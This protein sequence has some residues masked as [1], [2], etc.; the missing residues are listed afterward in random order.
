LFDTVLESSERVFLCEM[1]K[2]RANADAYKKLAKLAYKKHAGEIEKQL[3]G[4]G[5]QLDTSLSDREHKVFYNP[6][7]KK[8]VVAYRGTDPRDTSSI[9]TDVRSDYHILLGNEGKD[10]RFKRATKQ[11][12]GVLDKYQHQ[13][14][15]F[16][17]T[18]HS[19]GG[20][21][22][23]HV[24]KKFPKKVHENLS[25]SRGSGLL[26]PFRTRP[27]NTW[28]Y[29]H[30]KDPISLGARLSKDVDGSTEHSVVSHTRVRNMINAHDMERLQTHTEIPPVENTTKHTVPDLNGNKYMQYM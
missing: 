6:N 25:Y 14:Y 9:L 5:F 1:K 21:L 19:L 2:P 15:S 20:A 8:V 30:V 26:E 16:D 10:S 27:Q 23:T 18:G 13:G 11:F 7:T 22:A 17:T 29:S 28:D 3:G 4:T 12:K 24:T